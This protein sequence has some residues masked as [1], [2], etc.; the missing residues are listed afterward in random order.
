MLRNH[1][2]GERSYGMVAATLILKVQRRERSAVFLEKAL[3][4]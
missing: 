2:V 3:F 1:A 4:T